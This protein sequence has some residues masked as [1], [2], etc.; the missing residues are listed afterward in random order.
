MKRSLLDTIE[1]PLKCPHLFATG[2]KRRSG[3]LL[4]GPPGTG[5]TMAAEAI[6]Y[7]IGRPLKLVNCAQLLSKWVG[8]SQ[9][10]IDAVFEEAKALDA[11]LVFDEAT[12]ALDNESERVVQAALDAVLARLN[13]RL[14]LF[15]ADRGLG[16]GGNLPEGF[17]LASVP[18][19]ALGDGK[20]ATA[21]SGPSRGALESV[22]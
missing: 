3:V 6:G 12:S 9:K 14:D 8:E 11:V 20:G 22:L 13:E 17:V 1:L 2:V 18:R 19:L 10:N 21:G 16:G 7:D 5:K 15:G 4:Y